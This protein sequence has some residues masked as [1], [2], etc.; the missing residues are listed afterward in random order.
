MQMLQ[1]D[2]IDTYDQTTRKLKS[3]NLVPN[4]DT[5]KHHVAI[6]DIAS[7]LSGNFNVDTTDAHVGR[8]DC[9]ILVVV[10]NAL[11]EADRYQGL[12]DALSRARKFI[13]VINKC[14]MLLLKVCSPLT[15]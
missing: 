9:A 11:P 14:T 2:G 13:V 5:P 10:P 6:L 1:E 4:F 12:S 15:K 3:L 8:A 7:I